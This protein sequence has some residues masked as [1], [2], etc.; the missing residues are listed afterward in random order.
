MQRKKAMNWS[1][2]K[3][4]VAEQMNRDPQRATLSTRAWEA[5]ESGLAHLTGVGYNF[6]IA[7]KGTLAAV[8]E[9]T[10]LLPQQG[11]KPLSVAD[12]QAQVRAPAQPDLN[13][14]EAKAGQVN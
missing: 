1:E 13:K 3:E 11:M 2:M 12:A 14:F 4:L 7:P 9:L 6:E 8:E 10:T 5:V